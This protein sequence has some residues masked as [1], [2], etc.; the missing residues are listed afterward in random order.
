MERLIHQAFKHVDIIGP[1]VMEGHYDLH[2][3]DG[4]I[5]LPGVWDVTVQPDW[6]ITM[7]MWPLPEPPPPEP[8]PEPVPEPPALP[9]PEEMTIIVEPIPEAAP[10]SPPQLPPV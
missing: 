6:A 10:P 7:V 1:H 3:P 5:I 2:G 9:P 8:E 4:Q